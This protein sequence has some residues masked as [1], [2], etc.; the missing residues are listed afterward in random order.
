MDRLSRLSDSISISQS[1]EAIAQLTQLLRAD[2]SLKAVWGVELEFYLIPELDEAVLPDFW[3][4]VCRAV[5]GGIPLFEHERGKGQL[6]LAWPTATDAVWLAHRVALTREAIIRLAPQ[7]SCRADFAAKPFADDYG[8]AIHVHVHVENS[9]GENMFTKQEEQLSPALADALGGLLA[10]MQYAMPVFCPTEKSFA[11]LV[12]KM[13]A[14]TTLSWGA[15]NR[16]T[17]L[18]LPDA[19]GPYRRIEHRVAGADADI[20]AVIA[21]IFGGLIHGFTHHL[22]P[23]AQIFGDAADAQYDLPKLS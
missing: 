15:N 21:V 11:R 10:T 17:A 13:H 6:E 4:A 22:A 14:P 12:P 19:R 8:S 16:T 7:F 5:P 20:F 9:A 1:I 23:D 3:R 18:R 2:F